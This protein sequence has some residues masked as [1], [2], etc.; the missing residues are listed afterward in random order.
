[1]VYKRCT[2]RIPSQTKKDLK[3]KKLKHL[4]R[5]KEGDR[6]HRA[7]AK[8]CRFLRSNLKIAAYFQKNANGSSNRNA[9]LGVD[10]PIQLPVKIESHDYK[11]GGF[12]IGSDRDHVGAG[13][14]DF[15]IPV[16]IH[17]SIICQHAFELEYSLGRRMKWLIILCCEG[18]VFEGVGVGFLV[19]CQVNG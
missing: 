4:K 17:I 16:Y 1:M 9:F 14:A 15:S 7:V 3:K 19:A 12:R 8:R 13:S 18:K 11:R 10:D 6:E 5:L 2:L